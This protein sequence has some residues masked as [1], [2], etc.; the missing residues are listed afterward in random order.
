MLE[1]ENV[2]GRNSPVSRGTAAG[3]GSY[4]VVVIGSLVARWH[5]AGG[6]NGE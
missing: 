2:E 1:P 3:L 5:F 6:Y 4:Q